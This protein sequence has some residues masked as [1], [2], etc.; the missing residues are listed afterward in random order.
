V[1]N[2]RSLNLILSSIFLVGTILT[3][4]IV[5]QGMEMPF[6]FQFVLGYVIYLFSY[7]L[8]SIFLVAANTRGLSRDQLRKRLFT[9]IGWFAF[10]SVS[11]YL[12]HYFFK[13]SEMSLGDL[14]IPFGS[15]FGLTFYDLMFWKKKDPSI[16]SK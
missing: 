4:F 16:H 6:S 9:F 3:V 5:Y 14:A 11:S 15:A 13:S 10:F 2:Y 8:F 7:A 12:N 1:K